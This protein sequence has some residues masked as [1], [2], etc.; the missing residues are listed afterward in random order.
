MPGYALLILPSSNRVY[1]DSA[2]A[3]TIAE[4]TLFSDSVLGGR[5][6]EIGEAVIGGVR[7]VT[8]GSAG[9]LSEDDAALLANVSSAY[10]LFSRQA[11]G[12]LRP[13]ELRP[14]G[15]FDDDLIT[16]QKYQGKTNEQ[17][18][19]L[20]LNATLLSS[21]RAG[22]FLTGKFS[23]LDPLCGRGTTL[24]QALMYGWDASGIDLDGKDFD[25]YEAFIKTWLKRKLIKHKTEL[26]PI[27]RDRKLVG[28]RMTVRFAAEKAEYLAGETQLLDVVNADTVKAGQFFKPASFDLIVTDAPYGVKHGS[29][30][31]ANGALARSPLDL[32]AAALPGWTALLRPGGAIGLA[33]NTFV[34]K[35]EA[36]AA[37]LADAGLTVLVNGPYLRFAHRVDQAI[38]RDILIA[39][40]PPGDHTQD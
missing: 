10:A 35:R 12:A 3:L 29:R 18:T 24:N 27:R 38:N 9:E 34:A 25:A 37:M 32:L 2:V 6:T 39:R 5:L 40:K 14:L 7:Y 11:D 30:A 36:V 13:V 4:L 23:V 17:F 22:G 15:K 31:P 20:L 33:S 1:A 16:I 28:R 19:K 8:F 21:A 26:V